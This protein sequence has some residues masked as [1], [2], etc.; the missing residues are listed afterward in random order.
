MHILA[1]FAGWTEVLSYKFGFSHSPTS[2]PLQ[3]H[4]TVDQ[5]HRALAYPSRMPLCMRPLEQSSFS[6]VTTR[7]KKKE[8]F[9]NFHCNLLTSSLLLGQQT[10]SSNPSPPKWRDVWTQVSPLGA[11]FISIG[12]LVFWRFRLSCKTK[13]YPTFEGTVILH[14]RLSIG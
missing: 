5:R 2:T 10:R 6:L 1:C 14:E 11:R 13:L 3:Q 4:S 7:K 12:T 8:N 9:E